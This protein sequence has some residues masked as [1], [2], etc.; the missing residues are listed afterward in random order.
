VPWLW[1]AGNAADCIVTFWSWSKDNVLGFTLEGKVVL[2]LFEASEAAQGQLQAAYRAAFGPD[3]EGVL[4][5]LP[6]GDTGS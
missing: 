3:V 6:W 2:G 1:V 5:V 4:F